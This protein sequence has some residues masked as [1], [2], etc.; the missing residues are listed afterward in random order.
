[1]LQF[2][3]NG[4]TRFE[5]TVLWDLGIH[6]T[7]T[8]RGGQNRIKL[9]VDGFNILNKAHITNFSSNNISLTGSTSNPIPQSQRIR[10]I[11]PPRIF[12]VGASISF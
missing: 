11:I 5:R 12:R 6:K 7:F 2:E 1:V 9:M 3:P 10:S 4:S 8:F